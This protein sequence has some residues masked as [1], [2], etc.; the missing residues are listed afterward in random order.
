MMSGDAQEGG[1]LSR[2]PH[3]EVWACDFEFIAKGGNRPVPVCM[4]AKELRSGRVIRLWQDD[5][6]GRSK[7]PFD[8]G[9]NALFVA[10][11]ASAELG[12]FLALDWP[13]PARVLDLFTEFRAITN[14]LLLNSGRSLLGALV[15][16][17]LPHMG[18]EEKAE[19]R[20][21]VLSGG[22]W[23]ASQ[24]QAI[25]DYCQEDVDAL[26]RL[27]PALVPAITESPQRLGQALLRGRYMAALARMEWAGVPIDTATLERLRSAWH[28]IKTELIQDVDE[29]FNV[30]EGQTFK[31]DR[32]EA[33]LINSGIP[34]PRLDSGALALD[35]DTFKDMRRRFPQLA[36]LRQ[37]RHTLSDLRLNDLQV[38]RDDRNRCLL[39]P[40]GARTSRNTPS[41]A[42]FVFGPSKWLRGLIKPV[43]GRGLAY[44]DWSHQEIAIAAALSG[45][46]RLMAAYRSG[47]PYLAFAKQAGLA[48]DDAT[49]DTHRA[50]RDLAKTTVLGIN[51]GMSPYGIAQRIGVGEID[52]RHMLQRHRETYRAFWAWTDNNINA[53]LLGTPLQTRFGWSIRLGPGSKVN[54]RSLQ[55][56]PMQANG[57]EMMRLAACM[58]TEAG[59]TICAPVHDAFLL[60]AHL[61]RLDQDAA[62]LRQIMVEASRLVIGL[63]HF[64]CR[65]DVEYVRWPDRYMSEGG[66][67]MWQRAMKLLVRVEREAA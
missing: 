35:D 26:A 43:A 66:A 49:K 20:D 39:S 33:Y 4:V 24:R 31:R 60:E 18:G 2:L 59:L 55:N 46:K 15:Y 14:G 45:D 54:T 41:N 5:L 62:D 7:P 47:D 25:L 27:L 65:V 63:P 30:F 29:D 58:A 3:S 42:K 23:D 22:P 8:M 16:F 11:F 53:A 50:V 19:M 48:P 32:F 6:Q 44:L 34:W 13:M 56:Y 64:T 12:C 10:Y 9:P 67:D 40:F 21:L 17:Q 38:G 36:P 28:R 1:A 57:A 51:Y 52:A 37:L 61:D